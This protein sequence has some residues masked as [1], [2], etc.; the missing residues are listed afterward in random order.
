MLCIAVIVLL[1]LF[2]IFDQGKRENSAREQE[3]LLIEPEHSSVSTDEEGLNL[4]KAPKQ[5]K[6][7]ASETGINTQGN[8]EDQKPL[9][10]I[11]VV[12]GNPPPKDP[13]KEVLDKQRQ[14]QLVTVLQY[15]F[16]KQR[17]ALESNP[18]VYKN[19]LLHFSPPPPV[20]P[21]QP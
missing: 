20:C 18:V 8:K 21:T 17:Q 11:E 5:R 4:P 7:L 15:R 3:T 6:G 16:E 13:V 2:S 9:E 10:P 14:K 1:L 12:R 19:I